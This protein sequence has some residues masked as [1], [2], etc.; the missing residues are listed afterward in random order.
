MKQ[1]IRQS[2]VPT[3]AMKKATNAIR[4][5]ASALNRVKVPPLIAPLD[6]FVQNPIW[7]SAAT[8]PLESMAMTTSG[9]RGGS[10][11]GRIAGVSLASGV[12]H[13]DES[14]A[15]STRIFVSTNYPI[16]LRLRT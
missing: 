3:Q 2:D 15:G 1:M 4:M 5:F 8:A 9:R 16:R 11:A 7:I 6:Q 13:G 14:L 12:E 10:A